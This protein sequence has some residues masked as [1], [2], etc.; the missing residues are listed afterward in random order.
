MS[1]HRSNHID[2]TQGRLDR[3]RHLT[4]CGGPHADALSRVW[5]T[6]SLETFLRVGGWPCSEETFEE[7][8]FSR[9]ALAGLPNC[10]NLPSPTLPA[11]GTMRTCRRLRRAGS[12][13]GGEA[14]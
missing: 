2:R 14:D 8:D 4:G 3:V 5:Q 1:R 13:F 10:T 6:S 7:T 12:A 11:A 9:R